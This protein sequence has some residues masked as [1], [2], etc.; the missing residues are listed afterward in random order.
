MTLRPMQMKP[1]SSCSCIVATVDTGLR[2]VVRDLLL[3]LRL[4]KV[5]Y[6]ADSEG[7]IYLLRSAQNPEVIIVQNDLP[8]GGCLAVARFVRW[9]KASPAK[10]I[11]IIAIGYNWTKEQVLACH[12]EG[13]NEVMTLPTSLHTIQ[14]TLLSGNYSDRAFVSTTT[15]CGPD[16]RRKIIKGYQ[17]PFR[18]LSDSISQQ[19][20]QTVDR[21]NHG[22]VILPDSGPTAAKEKIFRRYPPSDSPR[23]SVPV[24]PSPQTAVEQPSLEIPPV[25]P[26]A[27]FPPPVSAPAV[28]AS[29]NRD[30][31]AP[32]ETGT[33][34]DNLLP[35]QSGVLET[36][37]FEPESIEANG[38]DMDFSPLPDET[39]CILSSSE[40]GT[41]AQVLPRPEQ[42]IPGPGPALESASVVVAAELVVEPAKSAITQHE[43]L[44]IVLKSS[45]RNSRRL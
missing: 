22:K 28:E 36:S 3:S 38:E 41:P 24:A 39:S 30:A 5:E 34:S 8:M 11:P 25:Q 16:R 37:G 14:R 31:A 29:E 1:L 32:S 40:Q 33:E 12:S 44:E 27:I 23:A 45:S 42:A 4:P 15:Y 43:L 2:R 35:T 7:V 13:I 10:T 17:G 18:R 19:I 6:C 21:L 20:S 9:N 26:A